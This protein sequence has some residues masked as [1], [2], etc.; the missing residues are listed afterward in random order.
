LCSAVTLT[1]YREI[2]AGASR[3]ARRTNLKAIARFDPFAV[4]RGHVR[5]RLKIPPLFKPTYIGVTVQEITRVHAASNGRSPVQCTTIKP[6]KPLK[7]MC[8]GPKAGR[9]PRIVD[10]RR[11]HQRKPRRGGRRHR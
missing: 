5:M 9:I 3:A 4:K 11:L 7:F 8:V 6:K 10:A 1:F 2:R